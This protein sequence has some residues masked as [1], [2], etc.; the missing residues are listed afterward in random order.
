MAHQ[1]I[2][3]IDNNAKTS[4][5][6]ALGEY[7]TAIIYLSPSDISVPYGGANLCGHA[8]DGCR[9][10]C[11]GEFAGRVWHQKTIKDARLK[12]TLFFVNQ[13]EAF[14][15]QLDDEIKAFV[16]KCK[17]KGLKPAVRLNG[18]T[19]IP[20]ENI[21][22]PNSSESIITNNPNVTFYDY[23]KNKRRMFKFVNDELPLNYHLTF[24][25]DET[26]DINDVKKLVSLGGNVAVVFS[27]DLN[28]SWND[29]PV[30]NGDKHDLRFT[31]VRSSIVGLVAKGKARQD[32]SG[33]VVNN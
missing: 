12:K 8:S 11:L 27:S 21:K 13:R 1:K 5:S 28:S 26:T 9:N 32:A 10:V 7:L 23:T 22:L 17:K 4:K 30:I 20:W 19:D 6:D 16:K 3:G 29:M 18:S 31:D 25:R 24:S 33:F 15:N 14:L 2:L